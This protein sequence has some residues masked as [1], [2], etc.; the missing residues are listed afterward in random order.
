MVFLSGSRETE[1]ARALPSLP[2][3]PNFLLPLLHLVVVLKE[4]TEGDGVEHI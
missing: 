1:A 2:P 4:E 3:R